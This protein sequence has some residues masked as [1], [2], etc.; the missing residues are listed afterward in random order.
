M[1]EREIQ[2]CFFFPLP[3][4][5]RFLDHVWATIQRGLIRVERGFGYIGVVMR[6]CEWDEIY[7]EGLF[8][9]QRDF[10]K[11][12]AMGMDQF[13]RSYTCRKKSNARWCIRQ[14]INIPKCW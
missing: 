12:R 4:L 6:K 9:V 14:R 13:S 10:E 5:Q 11:G 3:E 7:T 1:V 2:R 8:A